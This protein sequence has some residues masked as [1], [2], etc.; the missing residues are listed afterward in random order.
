MPE[1]PQMLPVVEWVR[2]RFGSVASLAGL[3]LVL[4]LRLIGSRVPFRLLWLILWPAM[5]LRTG[6]ELCRCRPNPRD[7]D[8]LA[9]LSWLPSSRAG[10]LL[11]IL[12][13]RTRLNLLKLRVYWP[14]DLP[15]QGRGEIR[16]EG[17]DR[18]A[19]VRRSGRP[20]ILMTLHFSSI[21]LL[22]NWLR[23]C[24]N[25]V[26]AVSANGRNSW[27]GH[28]RHL[29]HLRDQAAGLGDVAGVIELGQTWD[30]RDHL[31]KHK[32][33]L[34]AAD[35]RPRQAARHGSTATAEGISLPMNGGA[36]RLAAMTGASIIPCLMRSGPFFS[37]TVTLGEPVPEADMADPKRLSSV[38][39]HLL[40]QFLP[41][42]R[43]AP[44]ECSAE[45]L[46]LIRWTSPEPESSGQQICS[47]NPSLPGT[48]E[49]INTFDERPLNSPSGSL[50]R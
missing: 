14:E 6:W 29:S 38:C 13:G 36:I 30:M 28:R 9:G 39:D 46:G 47:V 40:R 1:R 12:L 2:N 41:V 42:L 37:M 10:R 48:A 15:K 22:F 11:K 43:A 49:A 16:V 8:H 5:L 20:A 25:S 27:N 21:T 31:L 17:A 19:E 35:F 7:F 23:A 3:W 45:L 4:V 24:G 32:L 26:A 33:L 18:L 50:P 44:E 34:V